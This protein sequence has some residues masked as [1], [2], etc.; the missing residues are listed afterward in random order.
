M[1]MSPE[2]IQRLYSSGEELLEIVRKGKEFTQQVVQE[3][4]RLRYRI[5]QLEQEAQEASAARRDQLLAA[6]QVENERLKEKVAFLE[7]RFSEVQEEN[8]DFAQRQVEITQQNEG[9]ANLY[10]A[11]FQLHSTLDPEEVVGIVQEI[12]INL[13]GAEEF[14][15]LVL[16]KRTGELSPVAWEGVLSAGDGQPA[17]WT[18]EALQ[19]V[20]QTGQPAFAPPGA[21]PG[22]AAPVACVPLSIKK[23]VVG[24]ITVSKLLGHKPALAAL[25]MEILN[26]LAAHAATAIVSSRLYADAERKLKTIESFIELLKAR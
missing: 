11:S 15:V 24:A 4:E 26:L 16:D 9:L 21:P 22:S 14:I 7:K 1:A 6:L 25:D 19:R 2:E 8:Q 20:V 23:E 5:V 10:V 18:T 13:V 17:R 3:N 12:L